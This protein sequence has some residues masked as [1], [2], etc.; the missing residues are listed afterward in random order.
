MHASGSAHASVDTHAS[1]SLALAL[2]L[3]LAH[4]HALAHALA[5]ALAL[6]YTAK[7]QMACK[8]PI[9]RVRPGRRAEETHTESNRLGAQ[10]QAT[11]HRTGTGILQEGFLQKVVASRQ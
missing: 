7:A 4:A 1:V 3:A 5:L 6:A 2:V 10:T 11:P 8:P 9:T